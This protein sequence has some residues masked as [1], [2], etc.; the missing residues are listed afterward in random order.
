MV[1]QGKSI[2]SNEYVIVGDSSG[3]GGWDGV[4]APTFDNPYLSPSRTATVIE[5]NTLS[6]VLIESSL[7]GWGGDGLMQRVNED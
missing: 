5:N 7:A 1:Y 6:P 2:I 3:H 4:M